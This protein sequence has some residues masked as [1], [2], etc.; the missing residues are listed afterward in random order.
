MLKFTTAISMISLLVEMGV[1]LL[2]FL[3]H[4]HLGP[5]VGGGHSRLHV[6]ICSLGW[7][8]T[9]SPGVSFVTLCSA[10]AFMNTSESQHPARHWPK[11]KA[12]A[13]SQFPSEISGPVW[14]GKREAK[15]GNRLRS[16]DFPENSLRT[17][18]KGKCKVCLCRQKAEV[19]GQ[20]GASCQPGM[21]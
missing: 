17:P 13:C 2:C 3:R 12:C 20:E 14:D 7:K 10:V 1:L 16:N 6:L 9:Q 21:Y 8:E 15:M 11:D 4:S 18:D 19:C 5:L